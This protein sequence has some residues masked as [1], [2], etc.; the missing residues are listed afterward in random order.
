VSGVADSIEAG[1]AKAE[2]VID[3]GAALKKLDQ[4]KAIVADA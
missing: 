1:I 3:S 2:E 4:L